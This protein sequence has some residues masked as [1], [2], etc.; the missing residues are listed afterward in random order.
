MQ[1]HPFFSDDLLNVDYRF[2]STAYFTFHSCTIFVYT[3]AIFD[4]TEG[5][6]KFYL[7]LPEV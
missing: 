3:I 1:I 4:L 7:T 6:I 2:A 5:K